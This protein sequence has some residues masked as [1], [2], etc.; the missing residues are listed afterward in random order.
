M[1]HVPQVVEHL[2]NKYQALSSI[3]STERERERKKGG[4]EGGREEGRKGRKEG[5]K[6]SKQASLRLSL[7]HFRFIWGRK[8]SYNIK[9]V[10]KT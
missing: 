2:P 5:R 9:N 6:E 10:K 7:T 3:L 4:R 1:E 8:Y